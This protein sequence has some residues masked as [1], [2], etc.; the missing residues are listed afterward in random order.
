MKASEANELAKSKIPFLD[1]ILGRIEH[2]AKRGLFQAQ[3]NWNL[4][5]NETVSKLKELG[6]S[7]SKGGVDNSSYI[8][9]WQLKNN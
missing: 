8:I 4:I 9:D 6:Y 2:Q 3:I 5:T 1:E 7:I